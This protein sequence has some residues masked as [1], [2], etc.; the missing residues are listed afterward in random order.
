MLIKLTI[1]HFMRF[2]EVEIELGNP[3]VSI[4]LNSSGK[5]SAIQALAL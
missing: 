1:R 2:Q 4:G 3:V 5:T